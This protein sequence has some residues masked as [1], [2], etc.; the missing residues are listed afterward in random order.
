MIYGLILCA[1]KQS[2][3][4]ST[5]PKALVKYGDQCLLDM[6]LKAMENYCDRAYVVCSHDNEHYFDGYN[7]IVID[8]GLGSGDAVMK[9]LKTLKL[10]PIDTCFI[11]WG[12]SLQSEDIYRT[13]VE[14]YIEDD[15]EVLIPCV[16]EENPYVRVADNNGDTSI[17]FSKY[18]DDIKPGYHDLSVFY[19]NA[20]ILLDR[21]NEFYCKYYCDGK[22]NHKHN[23]FE[24][25][26][27]FNDTELNAHI[28]NMKD[29]RDFS[30]N[31]LEQFNNLIK[32]DNNV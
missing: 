2:R 14:N 20:M 19:S 26:D 24:F 9:A 25:L 30:F 3:F 13:C 11:Q 6:N 32:E 17:F 18:G 4:G 8:S 5:L 10:K 28:Y 31:T 12:D 23:E 21:L 1:G 27:V 22:Y 16:Y 29:Y 15:G 7:K